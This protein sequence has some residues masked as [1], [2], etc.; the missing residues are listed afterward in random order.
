MYLYYI[1]ERGIENK[2]NR[3][4]LIFCIKDNEN[5]VFLCIFDRKTKKNKKVK[6]RL[7]NVETMC[8]YN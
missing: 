6:K 4:L 7:A 8:Y 1:E 2:K 5:T 3:Q